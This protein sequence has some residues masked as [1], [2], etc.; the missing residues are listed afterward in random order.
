MLISPRW[1]QAVLVFWIVLVAFSYI[2]GISPV[3]GLIGIIFA[4]ISILVH[5]FVTKAS[6][7]DV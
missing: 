5:G 1:M 7:K 4:T 6:A 3:Y 2:A